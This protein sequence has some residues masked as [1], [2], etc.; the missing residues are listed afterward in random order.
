MSGSP[1]LKRRTSSPKL[2][3]LTTSGLPQPPVQTPNPTPPTQRVTNNANVVPSVAPTRVVTAS[4]TNQPPPQPVGLGSLYPG[5]SKLP[6]GRAPKKSSGSRSNISSSSRRTERDD[7]PDV[8]RSRRDDSPDVRRSRRDDSPD[9]RRSRRDDSPDSRRSRR[10]DSPKPNLKRERPS[11]FSSSSAPTKD[12][13]LRR[14]DT[15]SSNAP[16]TSLTATS[17]QGTAYPFPGWGNVVQRG[18]EGAIRIGPAPN[19]LS[20]TSVPLH[21]LAGT[22]ASVA[23]TFSDG[24]KVQDTVAELVRNPNLV[25]TKPFQLTVFN[26]TRPGDPDGQIQT[27]SANNRRL[28]AMQQ[29]DQRLRS[30]GRGGLPAIPVVWGNP[31]DVEHAIRPGAFNNGARAQVS[32]HNTNTR[33]QRFVN[34]SMANRA[35]APQFDQARFGVLAAKLQTDKGLTRQEQEEFEKLSEQAYNGF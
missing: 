8:R 14:D 26:A 35:Q 16:S 15:P 17:A 6:G 7:S 1:P 12:T 18:N 11:V 24:R 32:T 27:W 33:V 22:H 9:V 34:V 30:E 29:A 13:R 2:P 19:H 20:P 5:D 31:Q 10:D 23:P 4:N 28:S 21:Q 3:P 25:Q